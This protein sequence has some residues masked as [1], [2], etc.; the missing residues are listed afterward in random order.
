MATNSRTFSAAHN[1]CAGGKFG[2]VRKS[3]RG[4]DA[5]TDADGV[6]WTVDAVNPRYAGHCVVCG[7]AVQ[8]AR[9]WDA[10]LVSR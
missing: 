2:G 4:P 5:V 9:L 7:K 3:W 8:A 10:V 1:S 6:E